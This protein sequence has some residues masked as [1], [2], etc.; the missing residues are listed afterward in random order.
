MV[1]RSVC[2]AW[3]NA[4]DCATTSLRASAL[5]EHNPRVWDRFGH[6]SQLSMSGWKAVDRLPSTRSLPTG[7]HAETHAPSLAPL[8]AL[9]KLTLLGCS[10]T[11]VYVYCLLDLLYDVRNIPC[12]PWSFHR[13]RVET[14]G[15]FLRAPIGLRAG[16]GRALGVRT[17]TRVRTS[18]GCT[19]IHP[20]L[21]ELRVGVHPRVQM[22]SGLAY[23]L[24]GRAMLLTNLAN[25]AEA[26]A[27]IQ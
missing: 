21:D 23:K 1:P 10:N 18:F 8:T 19:Y 11:Y 4:H 3:R 15:D 26:P 14:H 25:P 9:Q 7:S 27:R 13:P 24:N 17:Y 20:G 2:R 12:F 16:F 5:L 22:S 6:V